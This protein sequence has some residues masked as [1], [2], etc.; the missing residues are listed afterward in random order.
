[1]LKFDF[2]I[3]DYPVCKFIPEIEY[4]SLSIYYIILIPLNLTHEQLS[5]T[6]YG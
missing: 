2:R 5:I 3:K 1:M 4:Y 6:T